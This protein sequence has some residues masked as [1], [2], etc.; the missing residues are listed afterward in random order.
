MTRRKLLT[1]AGAGIVGSAAAGAAAAASFVAVGE[2][3]FA[4]RFYPG[5][6][7][8]GEDVGG[9]R[10]DQAMA[11]ARARWEPFL[12]NPIVF[13]LGDRAWTPTATQVGIAVDYVG[14]LRTAYAWGR[15]GSWGARF[16]EQRATAEAPHGWRSLPSF[17]PLVFT[18]YLGGIAAEVYRPASDASVHVEVRGGRRQ[19][20][21]QESVVGQRLVQADYLSVAGQGFDSPQRMIVDL[22]VEHTVPGIT[23]DMV[24]PVLVEAER[25][26]RGHIN[27]VSDQG[28]WA[29]A[30][31]ELATELAI[32]GTSD[33]PE[34]ELRLDY[35][36]FARVA[37]EIANELRIDP[38]EPKIRVNAAGD[39]VPTIEG[40]LG[41]SVNVERLWSRVQA[42]VTSGAD[43]VRVPLV[44]LQPDITRLSAADLQFDNLIGEGHSFFWGSA[45]N[46]VHN[47]N[48]GSAKIDGTVVAPGE[49]FSLNAVVGAIT[50]ANGFVEGLV[51]APNRTEPGVGGGICQVSTTLFRSAFWAGL[52]IDE[53]WQHVYR[54]GYYELGPEHPPGFDAAIWQPSQDLRF[55][56]D[57]PNY[58]L[59]R[60]E[61]DEG[62]GELSFKIMGAPVGREVEIGSWRGQLV[63]PPPLRVEAS[64]ELEPGELKRTDTAVG[65]MQA[66]IYR[67]V[68]LGGRMLFKDQYASNF[69]A[70]PERWEVGQNPDGSVDFSAVPGYVPPGEEPAADGGEVPDE[71]ATPDAAE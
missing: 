65:G 40:R 54:V 61:F 15:E 23:T 29:I 11:R 24:A 28:R 32:A 41:R 58:L 7:M 33:A 27:L 55:T 59:I 2:S 44:I 39:V 31:E 38:V 51:I 8:D 1:L 56:N 5:V 36:A 34:L 50:I 53:R 46:R 3:K 17:D 13:R 66:I 43:E 42:A 21:V 60:R 18:G 30:R 12:A 71:G 16:A 70:W 26:M 63:E 68:S 64:D 52:P 57:T 4:D 45:W 37:S 47:I 6:Q 10:L 35:Q 67:N 62:A 19:V 22:A 20:A 25:V 49:Q 14:P 9:L 48:N 69:A